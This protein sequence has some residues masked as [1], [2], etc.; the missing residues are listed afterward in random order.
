VRKLLVALCAGVLALAVAGAATA[1]RGRNHDFHA[2]FSA[3]ETASS[4]G[5]K[6]L[7]TDRFNYQPPPPGQPANPVTRI[8][9]AL[10][11]G[12]RFD[13]GTVP[14]CDKQTLDQQGPPGCPARS[15][16]GEGDAEA[17]TGIS[18]LDPVRENV[19]IFVGRN[20]FLLYFSPAAGSGQ[21]FTLEARLRSNPTIIVN[22]PPLCL[23]GDDP[24]TPQCDRGEAVIK[25]L[26]ARIS[27]RSLR[28]RGRRTRYLIRTP[29]TC[30]RNR[31]VTK[32]TYTYRSGPREVVRDTSPCS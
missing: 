31:W 17:F 16:V 5:I 29:R 14:N 19:Q 21:T 25:E 27:R 13:T 23:P 4:T 20:R 6:R 3:T 24:A 32:I 12:F 1:A 15:K 26:D 28:R 18:A 9:I 30:R 22:V 7:L 10:H 2:N 11:D 8:E